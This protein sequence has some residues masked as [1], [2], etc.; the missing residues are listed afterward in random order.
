[1]SK[2]CVSKL[3]AV[4]VAA[5]LLSTV[6]KCVVAQEAFE[7]PAWAY[8]LTDPGRGRGPD[9]GTLVSVPG[10]ELELTETQI[11]DPF[12]PPDWYPDEHPPTPEIVS[13]GR[14]PDVR[15]CGQCHMFHGLGHPESSALAGLPV[16][17]VVR[18]M[19]DFKTGAR[20]SLVPR[21]AGVMR[22]AAMHASEA[23]VL[24]AAQYYANVE[25]VKWVTVIEADRV[26]ETYVGAGNMRHAEPDG[27]LEPIGQRIIEIP[28]D[29]RG[30][31][32]RDPHSP[33]IA[34]VPP[35]SLAAGESLTKTGGGKTIQCNICHGEGLK[36]LAEVPG[37]A[38]R[39]PIYLARQIW[40]IK[41]GART[42]TSAA[43]MTA[44]VANL[45]H[46]D[47]VALAAYAAS[48]EP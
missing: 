35:G 24:V 20:S 31:E 11:N 44:V 39:S 46:E 30:A 33:F 2:P 28:E 42:G 34:Y 7:P 13:H 23:E 12:N 6:A 10:S 29:S 32:L 40:D 19:L 3:L 47:V 18:Q 8:P 9:D 1:M 21:R 36:G 38:G 22:D 27:G 15:A 17:Y 14:P 5:P 4:L 25:P 45:S 43:L 48:L 26:P 41:Y 16:N 37:I